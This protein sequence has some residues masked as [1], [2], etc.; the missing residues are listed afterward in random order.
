M[1][2]NLKIQVNMGLQKDWGVFNLYGSGEGNA[3]EKI[4]IEVITDG[5]SYVENTSTSV[6]HAA[7]SQYKELD[8]I[9][10]LVTKNDGTKGWDITKYGSNF[11]KMMNGY[12]PITVATEGGDLWSQASSYSDYINQFNVTFEGT[13]QTY[14]STDEQQYYDYKANVR[15]YAGHSY[16]SKLFSQ[17]SGTNGINANIDLFHFSKFYNIYAPSTVPVPTLR[18]LV[19]DDTQLDKFNISVEGGK[20][21]INNLLL[22]EINSDDGKEGFYMK[23]VAYNGSGYNWRNDSKEID[24]WRGVTN[25]M[26]MFK[27]CPQPDAEYPYLSEESTF[28]SFMPHGFS[29]LAMWNRGTVLS[30]DSKGYDNEDKNLPTNYTQYFTFGSNSSNR[31]NKYGQSGIANDDIKT[32]LMTL[33]YFSDQQQNFRIFNNYFPVNKSGDNVTDTI[34]Y[35][36]NYSGKKPSTISMAVISALANIY[37]YTGEEEK[38]NDITYI[39]DCVYL[40][41]NTTMYTKD[42]IFKASVINGTDSQ[43]MLLFQKAPFNLYVDAVKNAAQ[44]DDTIDNVCTAKDLNVTPDINACIKNIPI[45][46]NINYI[47]PSI[48]A[49]GQVGNQT[50]IYKVDGT[51]KDIHNWTPETNVL[52]QLYSD[53]EGIWHANRLDE[54]FTIEYL[55]SGSL[56]FDDNQLIAEYDSNIPNEVNNLIQNLFIYD[57]EGLGFRLTK[58]TGQTN[59]YY[60]YITREYHGGFKGNYYTYGF[61]KFIPK[62]DVIIPFARLMY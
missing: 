11:K 45:Q 26:S 31:N 54:N 28:Y 30:K 27:S 32:P 43:K 14:A 58:A 7:T 37:V 44:S 55:K 61:L 50:R 29:L 22:L 62:K 48:E 4:N 12:Y 2:Y 40:A 59:D 39:S 13:P 17:L 36:G 49:V 56:R 3:Y 5:D 15:Q 57:E 38:S 9:Q 16:F 8:A 18:S 10:P 53:K 51:H 35:S 60:S 23:N 21:H 25:G 20:P 24:M 34:S 47:E 6:V 42:M 33:V 1:A 46:I 19:H 52:Y 41:A